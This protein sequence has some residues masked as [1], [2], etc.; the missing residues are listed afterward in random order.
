[1]QDQIRRSNMAKHP[2]TLKMP[3]I[4]LAPTSAV[5]LHR[6]LY[7][8]MRELI[9]SGQFRKGERLPSSRSLA[10]ALGVSRNTVL[11][12]YDKLADENYVLA[13]VGSGTSVATGIPRVTDRGLPHTAIPQQTLGR[14]AAIL[15]QSHYPIRRAAFQDCDGNALHLYDC[16]YTSC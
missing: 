15:E 12:A 14:L 4:K 5:P 9:L 6:R 3:A 16:S 10:E 1:M 7:F 2:Q 8:S 13:K 11:N